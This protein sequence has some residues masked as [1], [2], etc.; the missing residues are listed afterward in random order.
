MELVVMRPFWL[1][2]NTNMKVANKR[3]PFLLLIGDIACLTL[4]LWLMLYLRAFNI[5]SL[6]VF[7]AHLAPFGILFL[8]SLVV[9]Y[10][11]GLYEKHNSILRSRL[12]S[13]IIKAQIANSLVA[14]AFFYFVPYF[15]I[16][17]KTNLFLYLLISIIIITLWRL[18]FY[19][20]FLPGKKRRA[21]IIGSGTEM[22]DIIR[23]VNNDPHYDFQLSRIIDLTE[24]DKATIPDI[25]KQEVMDNDVSM[26]VIDLDHAKIKDVSPKLFDLI[27]MNVDFVPMYSVYEHVFYRIPYSA[28][29][30]DWFIENIS[31][32]AKGSYSFGKRVIDI[33]L[34]GIAFIISLIFY[35]LIWIAIKIQD[36]GPLFVYQ[37]RLGQGNKKFMIRKFRSMRAA[38]HD[39]G[40]WVGKDDM[41]ITTLGRIMRKTSIDELPQLWSVLKGDLSLIGPRPDLYDRGIELSQQIPYYNIRNLLK[42]GLSGWAQVSQALPPQSLEETKLRL[43]YDIYYVKNKSLFMDFVI[44]LRT[45]RSLFLR[46]KQ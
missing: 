22:E 38:K 35:P 28:L 32:R 39:D 25:I 11:S 23:E 17:P 16:T 24:T 33:T 21:V 6:A 26:I 36:G 5:P 4:S 7:T 40:A 9:Y 1:Y 12:A 43:A 44:V 29:K 13:V 19:P 34:A 37:E 31:S 20:F 10:I 42:P 3:E 18:I 41:R 2:Y 30:H 8:A 46:L 15:G 27:F 45:I 14:I